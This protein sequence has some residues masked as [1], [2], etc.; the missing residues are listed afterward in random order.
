M[1]KKTQAKNL[2][3]HSSSLLYA[4][5]YLSASDRKIKSKISKTLQQITNNL[6]FP[7]AYNCKKTY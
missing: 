7:R 1:A 6:I 3:I 2:K 4:N 5:P